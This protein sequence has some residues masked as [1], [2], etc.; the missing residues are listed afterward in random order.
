MSRHP[1][2]AKLFNDLYDIQGVI[3]RGESSV[4]YKAIDVYN[5]GVDVALK[6]LTPSSSTDD[7]LKLKQR[8]RNEALC[9]VSTNNKFVVKLIDFQVL[10]DVCYLVTEF[11]PYLDLRFYREM[12]GKPI[13][14]D[15]LRTFLK[16]ILIALEHVHS[17]GIIHRDIRPENILVFNESLVKLGD[18]SNALSHGEPFSP[19]EAMKAPGNI[20][21]LAPELITGQQ[22]TPRS[23]IYSLGVTF[24]ELARD[25]NPFEGIPLIDSL[26]ERDKLAADRLDDLPFELKNVC[27]LM[28]QVDPIFRPKTAKEAL[29][30]LENP[31][32]AENKIK[33]IDEILKQDDTLSRDNRTIVL[34]P[35]EI[36]QRVGAGSASHFSLFTLK[37][38]ANARIRKA[39]DLF[40][41]ILSQLANGPLGKHGGKPFLIGAGLIVVLVSIVVMI[42]SKQPDENAQ[43]VESEMIPL[44]LVNLPDGIYVGTM[45]GALPMFETIEVALIKSGGRVTLAT[46]S[47]IQSVSSGPVGE[48]SVILQ[49]LSHQLK[50]SNLKGSMTYFNLDVF[51]LD[52]GLKGSLQLRK[53]REL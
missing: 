40:R 8:L 28:V 37:S 10:G 19:E 52:T 36:A 23:D 17:L 30:Y 33:N 41:A 7:L 34:S 38:W 29:S 51:N 24:I 35:E 13:P 3:G 32:L 18:F 15:Q 20:L 47:D 22:P 44:Q 14:H 46:L 11:A 16:Q 49:A 1:G 53:L 9:M 31:E 42:L 21:Y 45:A 12:L 50:L 25:K 43:S 2:R 5:G 39:T 6:V 4:V 48:E 27:R 26:A